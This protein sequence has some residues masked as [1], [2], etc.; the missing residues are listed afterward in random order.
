M[1][2]ESII[3]ITETSII[4]EIEQ[5]KQRLV[6][7]APG[8]TEGIACAIEEA[9]DRLGIDNVTIILDVDPEVYRLGFGTIEGLDSLKKAA[10]SRETLV[11]QHQEGVRI[12][13][14]IADNN[15]LIYTPTPLLVEAGS[16]KPNHPNA[17][18]LNSPPP[19]IVK[20]V[21]LEPGS[22]GVVE[23][24]F[25]LDPVSAK[26]IQDV[27]EDLRQN[28]PQAFDLARKVRVFNSIFEF[29]DLSVE[30]CCISRK[31]VPLPSELIGLANNEEMQ[32]RLRSSF[33]IVGT[34]DV[35]DEKEDI[36]EK[37]LMD[38]RMKID[39]DL[40]RNIHGFGKVLIRDNKKLF[41][42]RV[43]KLKKKLE[44]Y[45]VLVKDKMEEIIQKNVD[46]LVDDL[47]PSVKENMPER[48]LGDIGP[49]PSDDNLKKQ[50]NMEIKN[51]FG[52]VNKLVKPMKVEV[53]FKGV[54]YESL[55]NQ[56]FIEAAKKAFPNKDVFHEEYD[57]A[58]QKTE[59]NSG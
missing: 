35:F 29:V 33:K 40:L 6:Y 42:E 7:V 58:K 11:C 2:P 12:G 5:V 4:E 51:A 46:R 50:L 48:W 55:Q 25:G 19:E 14:L 59:P 9:W 56:E 36:T 45:E 27:Q 15:T 30:N 23:R 20:D 38:E 1:Q 24:T 37:K 49:N 21:G 34:E 44:T 10:Q 43:D 54:T 52:N 16:S 28:P 53:V 32:Q 8:I 26:E 31:R 39:S 18:R 13:L 47:F 41:N 17:I 3:N 57:T 22:N